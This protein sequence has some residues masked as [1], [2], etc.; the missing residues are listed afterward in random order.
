MVKHVIKL[1]DEKP[2]RE[3]YRRIPPHQYDEVKKHLKEMIEIGAIR[4][5]QSPWASAI[6]L[7]CKKD[8]SLRFCIDLQKL[9]AQTVKDAQTFP[10][11]EDSLDSL[12]GAVI[13]T[14]LDLKSGYWQVEL[15]EDSILYTYCF[16]HRTAQIL[17]MSLYVSWPYKC[18]CNLPT[19]NGE[20]FRGSPLELVHHLSRWH[21]SVFQN[22][23]GAIGKV[24]NHFQED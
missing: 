7:V 1:D 21:H 5:F 11:I 16:Y 9:N 6:V 2:F 13:F 19:F 20:L 23:R 8:G 14:S 4:K 18:P 22:T 17:Q 15:D 10:W 12:N 24:R 3:W